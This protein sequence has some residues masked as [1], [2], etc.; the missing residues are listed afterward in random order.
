MIGIVDYQAG[1]LKSVARALDY[2]S[3]KWVISHESSILSTCDHLIVP[4]VGAAGEAMA[5]LRR[6]GL[7]TFI[8]DANRTGIPILGICLGTQVIF[9]Y[10]EEND[11]VCLGLIPGTVRR[12]PPNLHD[13]AQGRLKVPHMGWNGVTLS[14]P[15][16]LFRDV[17]AEAEFYFVHSYFPVPTQEKDNLGWTDYGIT[18]SSV[19]ARN[20]LAAVQFH[21]EKSGTPGLKILK[22]FCTWTGDDAK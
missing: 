6:Q 11:T 12:F 16:P 4:G 19:I 9:D 5:Y 14:R 2:F 22:N 10:S 8:I 21:P 20:N 13:G 3:L 7:D 1:N 18:F 17:Q 15:H